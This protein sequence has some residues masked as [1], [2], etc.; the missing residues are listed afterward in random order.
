MGN[1]RA[2]FGINC[3]VASTG[4]KNPDYVERTE[5]ISAEGS[6]AALSNAMEH[7]R[8]FADDYLSDPETD[9]TTVKLLR[10]SGPDGDVPFNVEKAIVKRSMLEHILALASEKELDKE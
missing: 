9:L 5:D 2:T 6:G 1:Y 8:R 7:A 4:F 3:G 10:L